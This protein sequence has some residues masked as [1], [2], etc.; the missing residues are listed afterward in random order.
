MK[1]VFGTIAATI[2]ALSLTA[3]G[4]VTD[5]TAASLVEKAFNNGHKITLREVAEVDRTVERVG[6]QVEEYPAVNYVELFQEI[7]E[8]ELEGIQE[9]IDAHNPNKKLTYYEGMDNAET[10]ALDVFLVNIAATVLEEG[11]KTGEDLQAYYPEEMVHVENGGAVADLSFI[12]FYPKGNKPGDGTAPITLPIEE[13]TSLLFLKSKGNH[14]E[15][16][17]A[18]TLHAQLEAIDIYL[19]FQKPFTKT[20]VGQH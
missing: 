14:W 15:I 18:A 9:I 20:V 5:T 19:N 10:A 16:D 7:P 6:K 13:G 12:E 1:K 4:G 2:T 8:Q 3:C 11:K 17:G